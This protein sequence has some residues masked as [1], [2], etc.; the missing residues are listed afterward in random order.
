MMWAWLWSYLRGN[1]RV[2]GRNGVG[3]GVG[4]GVRVEEGEGLRS[5]GRRGGRSELYQSRSASCKL[6]PKSGVSY[7]R[8]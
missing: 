8:R 1:W 6:A 4:V 5:G 3:V 2:S 7:L